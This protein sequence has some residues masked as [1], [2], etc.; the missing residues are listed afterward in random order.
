MSDI[1]TT[2]LR[3]PTD[4]HE[5]VRQYAFDHRMSLNAVLV[6]AVR[7]WAE[8]QGKETIGGEQ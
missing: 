3:L 8:R 4:L 5:I 6:L 1:V 7:E 2:G